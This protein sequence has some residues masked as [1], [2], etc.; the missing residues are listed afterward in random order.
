MMPESSIIIIDGGDGRHFLRTRG[1]SRSLCLS[2]HL[3]QAGRQ[4]EKGEKNKV[5]R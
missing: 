4:K 1:T 5:F 2:L 3:F